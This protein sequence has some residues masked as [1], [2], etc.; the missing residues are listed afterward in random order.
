L[1]RRLALA[2]AGALALASA[3]AALELRLAVGETASV[4]FAGASAAFAV[5]STL[6][7]ASALAGEVLLVGRRVGQTI[8]TVITPD[9]I[10][11]LVVRVEASAAR[12]LAVER[13][14]DRSAGTWEGRYDSGTERLTSSLSLAVEE[15][16]RSAHL[17]LYGVAEPADGSGGYVR[18]LPTASLALEAP[19][20]SLV[21]FDQLVES[22]PLTLD[23]TILRG[24]HLRRDALELHA[25]IASATPWDDLLL[26]SSGDRAFGFAYRVGAGAVELV[27]RLLW[28]PDAGT[29]VP[30]VVALGFERGDEDG[31]LRLRGELGWSDEPG[32]ALDLDFRAARQ[33]GWLEF[34]SRPSGFAAIG[35]ARPAG[36]Y[37]D[38]AWSGRLGERLVADLTV[39]ANR[40]DLDGRPRE[41]ESGRFELRYQAAER[42]RLTGGVG[43]SGYRD[44]QSRTPALRRETASAGVSYDAAELGVAARYRYQESSAASRGGHGGRI[45][46][47]GARGGWRAH[48][49]VD[50]QEDAATVELVLRDR[51]DLARAFA[52]LGFV[53]DTPEEILRLV[54]DNGA[55]FAE[56]GVALGELEL[57]PLRLQAGLDAGWRG[58]GAARPEIR[59]RLLADDARGVAHRR[60][61]LLASLT[62]SRRIFGD[63][64]LTVGYTRW[65]SDRD[66]APADA[67]DSVEIGLRTSLAGSGLAGGRRAIT[68]R[69]Y[70]DD[71]ATGEVG[72]EL[73]PLAGVEVTLDGRLRTRSDAD[74]RFVFAR[75]GAGEHRVEAALPATPGAY[76]TAPSAAR[77]RSGGE[78][79]FALSFGAARLR[80]SVRNDAGRPLAGVTVRLD[81][82]ATATAV[83]DSGGVFRF[84][85]VPGT[86]RL[87]VV[88]DSIAAGHELGDLRA[89]TVELDPSR[90]AVIDFVLRAQRSLHGTVRGADGAPVT[91][92]A[93]ELD[94]TV[95]ADES[96]RFALRGLPAGR[97][98][99]VVKSERGESRQVV[100]IPAEPV[101]LTG[102]ELSAP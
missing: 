6:V 13:T 49:F 43:A 1:R 15:G 58:R 77:V 96:G 57:Q 10:A 93:L 37:L 14:A 101:S 30:G 11:T 78:A 74:G 73:A 99:L 34:A 47:R 66:G 69:V 16:D 79:E 94:R 52:E 76:F 45:T 28:L 65:T 8:V 91:V 38:G 67:R 17:R 64:H 7:E 9:A 44:R 71:L 88:A 60:R 25:G 29:E 36:D 12:A 22:S 18:A 23:G 68:G 80:G 98:T 97:L 54:R 70:R 3:A 53:A 5:D 27:P 75:P 42:W 33:H 39:S 102:V 72:P 63:T 95:R 46:V 19:G 41:A 2:V 48:L 59:L 32:G 26:P 50:A 81:G 40:L 90:P 24:L 62:A 89:Q 84:A 21:L 4:P 61:A 55:L 92:T 20:R 100:E 83:T 87:A 56:R 86:A 51:P 35:V 85:T 31:P 82:A